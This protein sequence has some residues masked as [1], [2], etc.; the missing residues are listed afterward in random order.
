[1]KKIKRKKL[2]DSDSLGRKDLLIE[3]EDL[4]NKCYRQREIQDRLNIDSRNYNALLDAYYR[5]AETECRNKSTTRTFAEVA[6]RKAQ[7]IR[8]LEEIKATIK[9]AGARGN[10][11]AAIKAIKAQSDILDSVIKLGQELGLIEKIPDKLVFVGGR[12]PREMSAD[13][14]TASCM[15]ELQEITQMVQKSGKGTKGKSGGEKCGNVIS[16]HGI[17]EQRMAI[18][19]EVE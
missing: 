6:G 2:S 15:R 19:E 5:A 1:M 16:F 12:D 18:K 3:F 7:L 4:I 11:Q 17:D 10:H 13:E 9:S 8:D 14:I